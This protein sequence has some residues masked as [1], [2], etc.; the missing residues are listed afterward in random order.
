MAVGWTAAH[1]VSVPS[2][3]L[4]VPAGAAGAVWHAPAVGIC[5]WSTSALCENSPQGTLVAHV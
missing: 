2:E 3:V 4:A 1:A 5:N